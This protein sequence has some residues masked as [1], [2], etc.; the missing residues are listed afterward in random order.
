MKAR[1]QANNNECY[2]DDSSFQ[3]KIWEVEIKTHF[4]LQ[5]SI[6]IQIQIQVIY[7]N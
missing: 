1:K 6:E 5:P 7:L 4:V 2:H 3:K